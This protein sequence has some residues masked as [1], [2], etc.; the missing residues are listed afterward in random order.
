[1][2]QTSPR[3]GPRMTAG[4][5]QAISLLSLT[6]TAVL[7]RVALAATE[8]PALRIVPP[9]GERQHRPLLDPDGLASPGESLI[10]HVL[11]QIRQM[12]LSP[13]DRVLALALTE[14]L[15]PTGWLGTELP[16]IARGCGVP[17]AEME[18][19][20]RR[21]QTM[22]PSGL[23]ARS[24]AECLRLQAADAGLATSEVAA[25]LDRLPL[26][27]KGDMKALAQDAGIDPAAVNWAARVIRAL[28]PKPGLAFSGPMPPAAPPDLV[29]RRRVD[30]WVALPHP[31]LPRL[32]IRHDTGDRRSASLWQQ[33]VRRR[34][35]LGAEIAGLILCRQAAHLDE[36]GDLRAITSVEL[37][38]AVGVHVATVNRILKGTTIEAPSGTG[39]LRDWMARPVRTGG[40]PAKIVS[41]RLA[42]LLA[43]P[44]FGSMSDA[45]LAEV[46]CREGLTVAR[47]TVAKYRAELT[48]KG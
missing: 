22:E 32:E 9:E 17:L 4:I 8:N 10:G 43:S 7:A 14:A 30:G 47:R 48:R 16:E 34:A 23:F 39:P 42:D 27:A 38:A 3:P 26:L 35:E 12:G 29:A 11:R 2:L 18:A 45:R 37:A 5:R 13:R 24:L 46:L 41:E 44:T 28:N 40:P 6:L 20:L 15:E 33:A 36:T 21:L 25:V 1:M 31:A 19:V